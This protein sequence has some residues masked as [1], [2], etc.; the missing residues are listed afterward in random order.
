MTGD[1]VVIK[2]EIIEMDWP[3]SSCGHINRGRDMRCQECHNPKES[4]EEYRDPGA[5]APAV[6][7]PKLLVL[8]AA[9]KHWPCRFCNSHQRDLKDLNKCAE[10]GAYQ[11]GEEAVA[12]RL[13]Q[14]EQAAVIRA[15]AHD[16][17]T[18]GDSSPQTSFGYTPPSYYR[19]TPDDVPPPTSSPSWQKLLWPYGIIGAAIA[20]LIIGLVWLL[21]PHEATVTVENISWQR[22]IE[23]QERRIDHFSEWGSPPSDAINPVC[24]DEVRSQRDCNP[25]KCGPKD[26]SFECG[27]ENYDCRI[28]NK[29][30]GNGFA[31]RS[32]I[33]KQRKLFCTRTV[34]KTCYQSCPVYEKHC[35]YDA[36]RW[37]YLKTLR[38]DGTDNQPI[39]PAYQ[40]SGPTQ[41]ISSQTE[42][43]EVT[44]L[45][46]SNHLRHNTTN[47]KEFLGYSPRDTWLVKVNRAGQIWPIQKLDR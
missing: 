22:S 37:H 32:T 14:K 41:H 29:S 15:T 1:E 19:P 9:H 3:C 20:A 36:P 42:N 13:E 16:R 45:H 12:Q 38:A 5:A 10:C 34:T 17:S 4:G 11:G 43:Y 35:N 24:H 28:E 6:T 46:G 47:E 7:D 26:E 21:T 25:Y 23:I 44:F 40:L 30:K 2:S 39:W 27:T 31:E 33:C 8:A 18:G